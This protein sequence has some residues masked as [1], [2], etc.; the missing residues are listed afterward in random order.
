[1]GQHHEQNETT[2]HTQ[3]KKNL[4]GMAKNALHSIAGKVGIHHHSEEKNLSGERDQKDRH[5]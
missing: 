2:D 4:L 1:M 5:E 3:E